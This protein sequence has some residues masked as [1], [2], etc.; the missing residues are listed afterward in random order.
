MSIL[1]TQQI[2]SRLTPAI[3][4]GETKPYGLDWTELLAEASDTIAG[5]AWTV[6]GGTAGTAVTTTTASSVPI[7]C[8]SDATVGSNITAVCTITTAAS[9]VHIRTLTIEIATL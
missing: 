7:T 2:P 8:A 6:T 5:A 9:K 3:A 4:P 1:T